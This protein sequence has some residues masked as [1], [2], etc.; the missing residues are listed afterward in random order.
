[1]TMALDD[2]L[3]EHN[4]NLKIKFQ[5]TGLTEFPDDLTSRECLVKN[6]K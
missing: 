2:F 3:K 6:P 4:K 1:M 5:N